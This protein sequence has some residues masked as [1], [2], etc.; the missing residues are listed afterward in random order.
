MHLIAHTL[1][2]INFNSKRAPALKTELPHSRAVALLCLEQ[3]DAQ[4]QQHLCI[5]IMHV[6]G[7]E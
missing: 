4:A 2:T 6:T 3:L 5:R 1:N 7:H